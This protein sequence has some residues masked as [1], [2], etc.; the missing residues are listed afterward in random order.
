MSVIQ[1][2]GI[3]FTYPYAIA[4]PLVRTTSTNIRGCVIEDPVVRVG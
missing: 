3:P 2:P 4:K 1:L